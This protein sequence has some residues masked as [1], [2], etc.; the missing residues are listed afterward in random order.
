MFSI[1]IEDKI[2]HLVLNNPDKANAMNKS[3]W[4]ELPKRMQDLD[5]DSNCRVIVV[6]GQGKHFSAGIDLEMIAQIQQMMM[7]KEDAG[8]VREKLRLWILGLQDAFNAIERCRKPVIAMIHGACI[9]GAIDLISACDMRYATADARF[10]VKEIDLAIVADVGTLQ[11]LPRIIPE[12]I[13]RELAYTAR[14]ISGKEA[15]QIGLINQCFDTY[16]DL[17]VGVQNVAKCI[18]QKSPLAI[19]GTKEILNYTRDHSITDSLNY[20]A[21]WNAAMLF[22]KDTVEANLA[23]MQKRLP[24]FLD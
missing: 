11:R 21:T 16:E 8:R 12:G 4:E 1:N 22:S 18:A 19:R 2:A 13:A 10:C 15:L 3:F 20:V 5:Q 7:S 17:Q 24:D 14:T 9:G 23:S 6:S